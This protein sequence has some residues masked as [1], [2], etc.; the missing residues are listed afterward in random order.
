MKLHKTTIKYFLGAVLIAAT[1]SC[2]KYL[3]IAPP[4]EIVPEAYLNEESQLGAYTIARYADLLPSHANWSFGTFGIDANSD[5]MI[6]PSSTCGLLSVL[7]K[8][9]DC[10]YIS[11]KILRFSCASRC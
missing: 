10:A 2:N 8:I 4:S 11:R 1:A 7:G 5:N 6:N 9:V 3:D